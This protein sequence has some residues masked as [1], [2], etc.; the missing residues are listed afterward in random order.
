[1]PRAFSYGVVAILVAGSAWAQ[2]SLTPRTIRLDTLTCQD[3]LPLSGEQRDRLLIYLTGYLDGTHRAST[4]D[5]RLAG[6]RI[7]RAAAA[8]KAK[9][10][11][12]LLRALADAWSR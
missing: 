8:C 3:L 10:E 1:M 2:V 6:E 7:D 5:E 11:T 4:Y 9:P 12:P